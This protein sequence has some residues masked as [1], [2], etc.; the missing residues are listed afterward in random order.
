MFINDDARREVARQVMMLM[1]NYENDIETAYCSS[2]DKFKIAFGVTFSPAGS[3]MK[4]ET[5]MNFVAERVRDKT[6]GVVGPQSQPELPFNQE[7]SMPEEPASPFK[8]CVHPWESRIPIRD[9]R[10]RRNGFGRCRFCGHDDEILVFIKADKDGRS[11]KNCPQCGS[12]DIS[13]NF[14]L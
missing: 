4:I 3:G 12:N 9:W 13:G 11:S 14:S 2:D 1:G 8:V 7:K 6:D 5:N 10:P